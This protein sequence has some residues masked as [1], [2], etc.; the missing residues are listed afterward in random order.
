MT[1][2]ETEQTSEPEPADDVVNYLP[3][4]PR[5][6]SEPGRVGRF[7]RK[8]LRRRGGLRPV[9]SDTGTASGRTDGQ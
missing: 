2:M 9:V 5:L 4:M 6:S 8:L 1:R 7:L 3:G